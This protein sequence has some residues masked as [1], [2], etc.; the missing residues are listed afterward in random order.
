VNFVKMGGESQKGPWSIGESPQSVIPGP[1]DSK[2]REILKR[3]K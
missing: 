3:G 2:G 1:A